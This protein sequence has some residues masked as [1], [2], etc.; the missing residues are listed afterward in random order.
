[1]IGLLAQS[2]VQAAL[3]PAGD[4]PVAARVGGEAV[5]VAEVD[6]LIARTRAARRGEDEI[7]PELRAEALEQAVHRRLV[8]QLLAK[9]GYAPTDDDVDGLVEGL[10]RRLEAQELSLDEFLKRHSFTPEILRRQLAWDLMWGR[11]LAAEMTDE[12]LEKYFE[13]HR[14]DYDGTE[15]RVSQILLRVDDPADEDKVRAVERR[16][17]QLRQQIVDGELTFADA[18]A[19][20]SSAPSRRQ[21]GD[22]GFIPR[23]DRMT[24]AFSRA[25]FQLEIDDI[26][27]P[28]N[29]QFGVHIICC[30]DAKAGKKSWQDVR[31]ALAEAWTNQRFLELAH[32]QRKQ[33]RVEYTGAVPHLDPVRH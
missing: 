22:L 1:M 32:Q 27:P 17:A 25:A 4:S 33:A 15:L 2:V 28:V 11:Y 21:A 8:T 18:A 24:E 30:T 6:D 23:H 26:S 29:D 31:R 7:A 19:R 5:Y 10:K 3:K 12:A 16:A 13:A 20:H 14:R 9:A